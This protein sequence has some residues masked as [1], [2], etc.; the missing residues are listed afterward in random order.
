MVDA[1]SKLYFI[2]QRTKK[3]PFATLLL[4]NL[5]TVTQAMVSVSIG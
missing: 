4:T 3:M 5:M 2:K 1:E